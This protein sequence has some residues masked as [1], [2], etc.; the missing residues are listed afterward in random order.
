MVA[1]QQF[2]DPD[3]PSLSTAV[4]DQLGL[5]IESARG[6][7]EVVIIDKFEKPTLD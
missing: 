1:A 7:V 4:Q 5:K 6:P 2:F 3:A